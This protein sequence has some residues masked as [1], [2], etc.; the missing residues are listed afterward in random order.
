MHLQQV[1]CD[2]E[3][4]TISGQQQRVWK[5]KLKRAQQGGHDVVTVDISGSRDVIE[6]KRKRK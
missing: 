6:T 4:A 2:Q 5:L 3:A 1:Q